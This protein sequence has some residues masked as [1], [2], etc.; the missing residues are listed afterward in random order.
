MLERI[1]AL[2]T[3][4]IALP[5]SV[6]RLGVRAAQPFQRYVEPVKRATAPAWEAGRTWFDKREPREKVLIRVAAGII[7]VLLLYELVCAPIVG[8]RESLAARVT[9]RRSDLIE[10]RA[11][12]RTYGRLQQGLT[13][14]Q[15]RTVPDNANFSLFSIIEQTLSKSVGRERIGSITPTDRAVTGGFHQYSVDIKLNGITLAQV[16][17]TLYGVQSLGIPVTVANLQL[18][19]HADNPHTYDVDMSCMTLAKNG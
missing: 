7:A 12:I 13:Q 2:I 15:N 4:P 14:A 18:H 9:S 16:V 8:L 17:D 5:E 11:L 1:R 3:E 6:R 19:Q 10:L